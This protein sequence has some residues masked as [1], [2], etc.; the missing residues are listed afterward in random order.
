M[1]WGPPKCLKSF[2]VL[3]A[4]LHVAKGWEYR[5]RWVRQGTVVYCAFEGAHGYRKRVEALRRF[6][7]LA[8]DD[9]VPLHIISGQANLI[10]DHA[11][12]VAEIKLDLGADTKPVAVVLDTL[13]KSLHGSESKDADMGAYIRAAEAIRDAFG[14]VVIIVH[15]CGHEGTRP[16]GHSSLPGADDA[17]IA[18]TREGDFVKLEVEHMRDGPEGTVVIGMAQP[19]DVGLDSNG[20]TLTSL[21]IV[22]SPDSPIGMGKKAAWPGSLQVFR[23]ALAEAILSFPEDYQIEGG[24]KVRATASGTC[25]K[26]FTKSTSPRSHTKANP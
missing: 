1:V 23:D 18:V 14:C 6:H 4:M 24:P 5:D 25:G 12:L 11:T 15:H 21:V 3:G 26:F 9:Q 13:N 19:I 8:D 10:N 17:Q 7:K 16:R 22:P 2:T 20:R